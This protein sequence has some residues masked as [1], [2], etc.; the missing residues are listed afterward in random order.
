MSSERNRNVAVRVWY[1]RLCRHFACPQ[2]H[3]PRV[4]AAGCVDT[5][6]VVP[7]A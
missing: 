6:T 7:I 4:L 2:W 5:P 1:N 3:E